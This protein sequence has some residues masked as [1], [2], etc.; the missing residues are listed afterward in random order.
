MVV[1][2]GNLFAAAPRTLIGPDDAIV[3]CYDTTSGSESLIEMSAVSEESHARHFLVLVDTSQTGFLN[4]K[5]KPTR[6]PPIGGESR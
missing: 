5:K 3:S 4:N 6:P 1:L 2:K